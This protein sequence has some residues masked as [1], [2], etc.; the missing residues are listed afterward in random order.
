[1]D[2]ERGGAQLVEEALDAG[3]DVGG[4]LA[5]GGRSLASEQMEVVAFGA[6]QAQGAGEGGQHLRGG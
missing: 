2:A 1:M 3:R 6:C 4:D 5:G